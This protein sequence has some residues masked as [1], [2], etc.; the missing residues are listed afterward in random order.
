MRGI[1]VPIDVITS[2][3]SDVAGE[4]YREKYIERLVVE[5]TKNK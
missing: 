3:L 2:D 1:D 5:F 4:S